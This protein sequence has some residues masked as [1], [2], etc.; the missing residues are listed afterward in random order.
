MRDRAG[1]RLLSGNDGYVVRG[2]FYATLRG[3]RQITSLCA[4]LCE[5]LHSVTFFGSVAC[6]TVAVLGSLEIAYPSV[7]PIPGQIRSGAPHCI[8]VRSVQLYNV[9]VDGAW[10]QRPQ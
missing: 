9:Y 7:G 6:F 5:S 10:L 8:S 4:T 2:G 3:T 1:T